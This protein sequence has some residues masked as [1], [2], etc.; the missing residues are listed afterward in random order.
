MLNAKTAVLCA[1]G[2][3]AAIHIGLLP[4]PEAE[5]RTSDAHGGRLKASSGPTYPSPILNNPSIVGY[6]TMAGS[7]QGQCSSFAGY[8]NL[9]CG[10]SYNMQ[11]S[12]PGV[13][14]FIHVDGMEVRGGS[15]GGDKVD[16]YPTVNVDG[17]IQLQV[18]GYA[19]LPT[20]GAMG[21]VSDD[22]PPTVTNDSIQ[23]AAINAAA[24]LHRASGYYLY[25]GA[26]IDINDFDPASVHAGTTTPGA[27]VVG[28]RITGIGNAVWDRGE[29]IGMSMQGTTAT[30]TAAQ[31]SAMSANTYA[32]QI[33]AGGG[34]CDNPGWV[35]QGINT[36]LRIQNTNN[37]GLDLEGPTNTGLVENGN[38]LYGLKLYG[39]YGSA[40]IDMLDQNGLF[41]NTF[42]RGTDAGFWYGE[43]GWTFA[44]SKTAGQSVRISATGGIAATGG[45][46]A[47]TFTLPAFNGVAPA[48]VTNPDGTLGANVGIET[49][50][51]V[52][53]VNLAF[54]GALYLPKVGSST[55]MIGTNASGAALVTTPLAVS[56]AITASGTV[57]GTA[58][59]TSGSVTL[60]SSNG[61][62]PQLSTDV[63][64][65]LGVNT[66]IET[67]G[68]ITAT[69]FAVTSGIFL[70]KVGSS[71]PVL[72]TSSSGA[73]A[74]S[75]PLT[76]NGSVSAT[77]MT[78]S[79]PVQTGVYT[80]ASLPS[81]C[82]PG[83][84]AYA[85]DARKGGE[86]AGNGSGSPVVCTLAS[87][88]GA[89]VWWST[90]TDA[91]AV[92]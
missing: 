57:T 45:V 15:G 10:T 52:T 25:T 62:Q 90:F 24:T 75:T 12:Q 74:V 39:N 49:T 3:L 32:S 14:E 38:M 26:E 2:A 30:C 73:A 28:L 87:K 63:D 35:A 60:P 58:L 69:N 92:N 31:L 23:V 76:V 82:T 85:S 47:S 29:D 55:P 21:T 59:T 17:P 83:Q 61:Q 19:A 11:V 54:S 41:W 33:T 43:T 22:G 77:G 68:T 86:T 27:D 72:T 8:A 67:A 91:L 65:T 4:I 36:G 78:S 20:D 64:G 88:G 40:A 66:G 37:Y 13:H 46:S 50:G 53:A 81:G 7:P 48:L 42:G 5:A 84:T 34:S 51:T 56:G 80:V 16:D 70:A 1:A 89:A 79:G 9:A 71:Q 6:L 44:T 18:A